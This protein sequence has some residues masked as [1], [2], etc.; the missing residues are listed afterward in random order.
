MISVYGHVY[1]VTCL[2]LQRRYHSGTWRGN[3]TLHLSWCCTHVWR[4]HMHDV[5][6][7]STETSHT[8]NDVSY[9]RT[10]VVKWRHRMC[11]VI[12]LYVT[13]SGPRCRCDR[14]G[15]ERSNL[16]QGAGTERRRAALQQRSQIHGGQVLHAKWQARLIHMLLLPLVML[17]FASF[18]SIKC[19]CTLLLKRKKRFYAV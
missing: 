2:W 19:C 16:R 3:H 15:G 18:S 12:I 9:L 8:H 14:R 10:I 17:L 13:S 5:I 1:D 4:H 6:Y 11:D 7:R